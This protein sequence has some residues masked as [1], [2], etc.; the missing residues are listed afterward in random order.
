MAYNLLC[1]F[2]SKTCPQTNLTEVAILFYALRR[3]FNRMQHASP[4]QNH[5]NAAQRVS[6]EGIRSPIHAL[7]SRIYGNMKR[8]EPL[9]APPKARTVPSSIP[10][11]A[12]RPGISVVNTQPYWV[13]AFSTKN[14]S[15][16]SR[17]TAL[18]ARSHYGDCP[19]LR[20]STGRLLYRPI[21][22]LRTDSLQ[23]HYLHAHPPAASIYSILPFYRP[24]QRTGLLNK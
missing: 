24:P 12:Q 1:S 5:V 22:P 14:G 21:P 3:L 13:L 4:N 17:S 18:R 9:F 23:L 8:F 16:G 6:M 7:P 20:R 11:S 10:I 2:L 19:L 15:C